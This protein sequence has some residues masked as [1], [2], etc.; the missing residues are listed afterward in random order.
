M[1][2]PGRRVRGWRGICGRVRSFVLRWV[3][4]Y[5]CCL[6][7]FL[8]LRFDSFAR[9]FVLLV[10]NLDLDLDLDL[11]WIGLNYHGMAWHGRRGTNTPAPTFTIGIGL[12]FVM[13]IS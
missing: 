7:L 5:D 3:L 4:R 10:L 12:G 2:L 8:Q 9:L 13:E 1:I 11:D 6:A